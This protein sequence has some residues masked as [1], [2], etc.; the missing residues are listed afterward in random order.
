MD[1]EDHIKKA[2]ELGFRFERDYHGCAQSTIAAVQDTLGIR[3]DTVF[4][5]ASGIAGGGGGIPIIQKPDRQYGGIEAVIDKDLT[6]SVLAAEIGAA[7]LIILTAVP[8]VY[9]NFRKPDQT[10]LGAVTV[11][12]IEKLYE[13]GHFPP[14]SMGPKI[15]AVIHFLKAGGR[16]ALI[17][18]PASLPTAID[19]R[20]GT[21]FVGGV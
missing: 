17:T 8:Q 10:P 3:N 12:E 2:Y 11:E 7:L 14:G 19:G 20:A 6:S 21:H 4:Q 15:E 1:R 18:D 9:V 13:A 5:T 16:R